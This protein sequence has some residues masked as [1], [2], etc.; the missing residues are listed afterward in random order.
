MVISC[1]EYL[2]FNAKTI[3]LIASIHPTI[4][5]ET[6]ESYKC[7]TNWSGRVWKGGGGQLIVAL[8]AMSVMSVMSFISHL[9]I[10][11]NS[12]S[13]ILVLAQWQRSASSLDHQTRNTNL[14]SIGTCIKLLARNV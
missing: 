6:N 12:A 9:L 3:Q 4:S 8:I 11:Y 5:A 13:L 10:T 2:A 14:Q 1:H 7:E